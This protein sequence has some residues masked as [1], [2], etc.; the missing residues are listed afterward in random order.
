MNSSPKNFSVNSWGATGG[1]NGPVTR[2]LANGSYTVKIVN[3]AVPTIYSTGTLNVPDTSQTLSRSVKVTTT[4]Q[5]Q[6]YF[7]VG[8]GAI[9]NIN[10][11]GNKAATASWN[12]H[13]NTLSTNGRFNS[14]LTSSNGDV[15]SVQ[16][17]VNIGQHT[18][19]GNLYLGPTA[20]YTSGS[21]QV[22]G[23]IYSDYNVQFPTVT[24]PTTDTNGNSISWQVAPNVGSGGNNTNYF[25]SSGYYT[26]N[27]NNPILVQTNVS[28]TVDVKTSNYSLG[29]LIIN[30]GTTNSGTLV[31]YQESGTITL[32]GNSGGGAIN[33][34][35][36]NF[37]YLGMTNVTSI[38]LSGNSTFIGA[39]YAPQA[40]LT[41]NGG[42]NSNNLEGSAIVNTITMNGKY[43]FWFDLALENWVNGV[44]KGYVAASWQEL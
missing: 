32:G 38:T 23:T 37:V 31:M 24:L 1:T 14:N 15:A 26:I 13:T 8:L 17:I 12:S 11:N 19:L 40:T 7:F 44:N 21:N 42:G 30:G 25:T 22:T 4:T 5:P 33:N 9:G 10:M 6:S 27:N 36:E 2:T 41:L 39:I 3:G 34:R 16:G 43:D 29:G 35:P 28:V 18:I 20:T